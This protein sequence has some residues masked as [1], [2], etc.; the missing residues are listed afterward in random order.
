MTT[1]GTLKTVYCLS[2]KGSQS[3]NVLRW[4]MRCC[5]SCE[6]QVNINWYIANSKICTDF[7]FSRNFFTLKYRIWTPTKCIPHVFHPLPTNI[8]PLLLANASRSTLFACATTPSIHPAL[9]LCP[10]LSPPLVVCT[11]SYHRGLSLGPADP[12]SPSLLSGSIDIG[13]TAQE[14]YEMWRSDCWDLRWLRLTF[15]LLISYFLHFN[16]ISEIYCHYFASDIVLIIFIVELL[17]ELWL[18]RSSLSFHF[19]STC[20]WP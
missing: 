1:K 16:A 13:S 2:Q 17:A 10:C 12:L 6:A 9:S 11:L 19:N 15:L 4:A 14:S 7:R 3:R 20:V 8:R 5:W 18:R